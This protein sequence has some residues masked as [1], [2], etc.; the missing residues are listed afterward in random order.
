MRFL[1]IVAPKNSATGISRKYVRNK[2]KISHIAAKYKSKH[3]SHII[4]CEC[5]KL[6]G[7]FLDF[8]QT[9]PSSN[10]QNITANLVDLRLGAHALIGDLS[11]G[12][13]GKAWQGYDGM[14]YMVVHGGTWWYMVV[15][16]GHGIGRYMMISSMVMI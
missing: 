13:S 15:D 7:F 11:T 2:S 8:K 14:W 6:Q 16:D 3:Q 9:T 4:Y 12:K 5:K 1:F 10:H